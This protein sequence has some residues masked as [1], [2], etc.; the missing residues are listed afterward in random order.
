MNCIDISFY[1]YKQ[2]WPVGVENTANRKC[3]SKMVPCPRPQGP[4][5]TPGDG[6]RGPFLRYDIK[7]SLQ[8]PWRVAKGR[9]QDS[10]NQIQKASDHV[11]PGL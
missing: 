7:R 4:K 9:P 11:S 5:M 1:L 3:S 8:D 6:V 10:Q 2:K